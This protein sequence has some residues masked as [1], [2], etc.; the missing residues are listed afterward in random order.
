M[1]GKRIKVL[2]L[3]R[4]EKHKEFAKRIKMSTVKLSRI[5]TG[6]TKRPSVY[7][8]QAIAIGLYIKVDDLLDR[9]AFARISREGKK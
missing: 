8:I 3:L 1:I 6:N 7:D 9:K 5:I 2:L 4:G